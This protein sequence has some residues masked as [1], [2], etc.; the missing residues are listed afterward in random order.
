M[1]CKKYFLIYSD[2]VIARS[3]EPKNILQLANEIGL[4]DSEVILFG[5]KKAK[6]SISTLERLKNVNNG[7][8]VVVTG[9][10][11]FNRC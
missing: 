8:Y 7:K 4:Q 3:Q 5:N 11:N 2:I 6:I 9:Y 10:V 1:W